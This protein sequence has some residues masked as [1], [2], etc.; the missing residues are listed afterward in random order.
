M[1]ESPFNAKPDSADPK[2]DDAAS[3]DDAFPFEPTG[4]P[5]GS[6]ELPEPM[7]GSDEDAPFG[8]DAPTDSDDG[9]G[10]ARSP[11]LADLEARNGLAGED[12]PEGELADAAALVAAQETPD[13]GSHTTTP[14]IV[15]TAGRARRVWRQIRYVAVAHE[16]A[17]VVVPPPVIDD[18]G[19]T[20]RKY[21]F[22]RSFDLVDKP[23]EPEPEPELVIEPPP[24][25]E[26]VAEEPPPPT[27]SEAELEAARAAGYAEGEEAGH[28][29]A[30]DTTE[31]HV[32]ALVQQLAG[33]VPGLVND[34]DQA[35]AGLSH[36]AARLAH[37]MVRRLMPELARR[38]RTEEIEA[39][40]LDSLNKA[41]DQPR[42]IIRAPSDIAGHLGDRLE[43][44]ARQHGFA[45]RVIVLSEQGLGPSDVRVEWG[46]GGAERCVQRAWGDIEATVQ[47]V[48]AKLEQ[49]A[50]VAE[51]PEGASEDT[52]GS[53]A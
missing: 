8:F 23:A 43:T 40:V 27:F 35:I 44:V 41:L 11:F 3:S 22:E 15:E 30:S 25:V 26:I 47:R 36:E 50:P 33:A 13:S 42:I 32:A 7:L 29:A 34:R 28:K 20:I 9:D 24:P 1:S 10:G 31:A 52:I 45:G 16:K 39:V 17:A 5:G 48:V 37:A 38:Y 21:L 6:M 4:S 2:P 14:V 46:D 49:V 51:I 12:S 53:A 19:R 18:Q